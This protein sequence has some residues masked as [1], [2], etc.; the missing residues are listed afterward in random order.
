MILYV[1]VPA[2]MRS[3]L[4][5]VVGDRRPEGDVVDVG[6]GKVGRILSIEYVN[7]RSARIALDLDES[8]VKAAIEQHENCPIF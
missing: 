7:R 8:L 2:D 4:F 3:A 1:D 5:N 6:F